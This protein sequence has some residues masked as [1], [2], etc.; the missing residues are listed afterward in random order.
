LGW[1]RS[2]PL[3]TSP[4]RPPSYDVVVTVVKESKK[5]VFIFFLLSLFHP[6]VTVLCKCL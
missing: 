3:P 4:T 2:P 1:D 5:F 6:T